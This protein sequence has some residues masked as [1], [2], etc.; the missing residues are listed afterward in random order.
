MHYQ[1]KL[2]ELQDPKSKARIVMKTL[3][4]MA[5]ALKPLP[6]KRKIYMRTFLNKI[7]P[8]EYQ[9]KHFEKQY[10]TEIGENQEKAALLDI[11]LV[12]ILDHEHEFGY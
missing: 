8:Q 11:E 3:V 4:D 1:D 2:D 6:S 5:K 12:C 7:S 9:P 10:T